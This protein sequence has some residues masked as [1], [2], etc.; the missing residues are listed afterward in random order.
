MAYARNQ[1]K[2]VVVGHVDHGKSTLIGRLFY[3][4]GSLPEGKYDQLVAIAQRRGVPFEFA[5]LMDGLQA[6][7]DQ[8]ITI[9]TAQIW[10]RTAKREYVIIDAPGHKEFVKNMV[11][12]ASRADAALIIID[13]SEGVQE[14]TRRHGYLLRLIGVRQVV[15]V[16]NKMDLVDYSQK[17]FDKVSGEYGAFLKSIGL[18][19]PTILPVSARHGDNIASRGDH[20]SW[21]TGPSVLS[22]LDAIPDAAETTDQ[23]LRFPIQDVYRFDHR[24][25]LAGRIEAGVLRTGDQLLFLPSGRTSVVRSIE[26]WN[27]P[28]VDALKAGDPAGVTLSDQLFVERGSVAV[29]AADAPSLATEF[30]ARIFWLGRTPLAA[31]KR[32]KLKLVTQ[33][34]ECEIK[35]LE[36]V[37]DASTV[38]TIPGA[39]SVRTNDAAKVVIRTRRPVAVDLFERV[40]TLGR[41]VLVDGFDVA[42]GG[43]VIDVPERFAAAN[44]VAEA[45]VNADVSQVARGERHLRHGHR[46]AVVWLTG[47]PG[48]GKTTLAKSLERHLFER[49]IQVFV[50]DGDNI[51][52][53]LSADLGVSGPE[54]EENM[55][56]VAEVAKLFAEAGSVCI[57][58][59]TSPSR[60]ERERARKIMDVSD[61]PS[62][63][64]LE[65]YLG[66]TNDASS[67]YE[68]PE[69]PEISLAENIGLDERVNRVL[70]HLMRQIR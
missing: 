65:A 49:H 33:E 1:L 54:R 14:Q 52:P 29:H 9:D 62:I 58:S 20:F 31:G 47:V 25:I 61:G 53:G 10:F 37:I 30:T 63:P 32:Y 51:R 46:G 34:V 13:A 67:Q 4:T 68:P 50:L 42:G 15:V 66:G 60:A 56:R 18:A 21:F 5:N 23:P 26:S 64:F 24:R 6:E 36:E 17:V 16:V 44:V 45:G 27:S 39:D 70:E 8:N 11:T 7:R 41:L 43:I 22:A 19:M 69:H 57:V 35:T 38:Q 28:Q 48:S 12:G 3:D 2:L 40:P 55:R 59:F